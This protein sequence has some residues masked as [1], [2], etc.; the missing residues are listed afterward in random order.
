LDNLFN[1]I[2][3]I[4]VREAARLQIF[5]DDF[6]FNGSMV[7]NYE[8]IGNTVLPEFARRL[9]SAIYDLLMEKGLA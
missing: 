3:S 1:I 6:E 7:Q 4:I 2:L 8:L 5:D 9:A